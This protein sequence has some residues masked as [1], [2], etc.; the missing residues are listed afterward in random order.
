M[1]NI[2]ASEVAG[3]GVGAFL[4]CA[5]IAA[6][7]VDAFISASQRSSLGMCKRCG[8]LRMIA[9]TKCKGAGLVRE[10]SLFG[11]SLVDE[12]KEISTACPN[13]QGRGHFGCPDC[14]KSSV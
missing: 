11:L 12:P 14:S 2:T 9:C 8:N 7:K 3:F 13:C 4:L 6:P 5:T 10:G 1:E